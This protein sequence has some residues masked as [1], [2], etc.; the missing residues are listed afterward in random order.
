M[1]ASQGARPAVRAAERDPEPSFIRTIPSA[2]ELHRVM[3]RKALAG[4]TADREFERF[5]GAH[6][7]APKVVNLCEV[8][9]P[10]SCWWVNAR[11][12]RPPASRWVWRYRRS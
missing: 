12:V 7:P 9:I 4:C 3:R 6:H 5:S 2:P 1:R 8:I 10:F 11:T